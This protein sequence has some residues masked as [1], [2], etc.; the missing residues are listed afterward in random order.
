MKAEFRLYDRLFSEENPEEG[1]DGF[2]GC[3][4]PDSLTILKGFVEPCLASPQSGDKFQFERVGFF[5]T[6]PD[7]TS[8]LPVFNRTVSLRDTWSKIEK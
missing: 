1:E 3:I 8:D 5:S 6:D 4:N 2:L 7:S